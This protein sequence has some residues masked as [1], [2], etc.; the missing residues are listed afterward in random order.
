MR[1]AVPDL[2]AAEIHQPAECAMRVFDVVRNPARG[3]DPG[4]VV[5]GR[6]G[7]GVR[8]PIAL[9]AGVVPA[10]NLTD[11]TNPTALDVVVGL[12][13]SHLRTALAAYLNHA[14]VAFGC[15]HHGASFLDG[16]ASRLLDVYILAGFAGQDGHQC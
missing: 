9:R 8:R 14:S 6:R 10:G 4:I 3:A 13:C 5:E 1:A 12:P 16:V 15:V 2:A 7:R 11:L